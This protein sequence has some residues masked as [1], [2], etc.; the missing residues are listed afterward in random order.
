MAAD[1]NMIDADLRN[2][3]SHISRLLSPGLANMLVNDLK[4]QFEFQDK[5]KSGTIDRQEIIP[6]L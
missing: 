2:A 5:D 6:V 3:H 1:P 4:K